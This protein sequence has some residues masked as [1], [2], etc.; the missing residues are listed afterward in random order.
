MGVARIGYEKKDTGKAQ[1]EC[2]VKEGKSGGKDEGY[3]RKKRKK[4]KR[5]K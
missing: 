2:M 5:N 1:V 4:R 3:K